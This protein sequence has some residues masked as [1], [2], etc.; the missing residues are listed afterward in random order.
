MSSITSTCILL[1]PV[2]GLAFAWKNARYVLGIP[3]AD[4]TQASTH[5]LST[6][7]DEKLVELVG[8]PTPYSDLEQT[9]PV[10]YR[11]V[12]QISN[13]IYSGSLAFLYRQYLYIATFTALFFFIVMFV[14]A[15]ASGWAVGLL[16]AFAYLVGS[17][18]SVISGYIGMRIATLA[19]GRTAI[20]SNRVD[21]AFSVAFRAGCV[22]GFALVSLGLLVLMLLLGCFRIY[23]YSV[24][25]ESATAMYKLYISLAGY[26]L[27]GSSV[28]LFSRVGGGIYT[29]AADVGADLVGKIEASIPEDD[30]R[31]P[32][33][34]ADQVGDNV[35]DIAGMGADLFGSFAE[36][37]CAAMV[38]AAEQLEDDDWSVLSFP[39]IMTSFGLLCSILTAV[40]AFTLPPEN[41]WTIEKTLKN[42]LVFSTLLNT[43]V[44][45]I[46]AAAFLPSTISLGSINATRWDVYACAIAGLWCGLIIGFVTEYYTSSSYAPVQEIAESCRTGAATNIIFGLS[47]GYKSVIAPVVVLC[48]SIYV[49]FSL[50]GS[51]G[52]A[53]AALGVLSNMATSLTIDAFGPIADNAGGVAEMAAL[54]SEVREITDALDSA[55]NTTAAVGKGFA[56]ASA[57]FVSLALFAAFISTIG[58]DSV[59]IL[60]PITFS[61]LL[62]GSMLPY[63][64]S[65][66]T[67]KAVG[68][69]AFT[70]VEEVRDQWKDGRVLSGEKDPDYNR[71]IQISTDASL[72]EMILP[73][74]LVMLNPLFVGYLL[75]PICQAGVLAGTLVSGVQ[76]AISSSNT[77]GAWDNAKKYIEAGQLSDCDGKGSAEHK[78]SV[79]G[80][81]VGDP[82]KDTSGPSLNI[83]IKLSA[84]IS[85]VFATSFPSPG[86]LISLL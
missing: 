4:K 25:D 71:C 1:G 61:G 26:G 30:P 48:I 20:R 72:R 19:N 82:L 66:M 81:T 68:R 42:Q 75:G 46:A 12:E 64:F 41:T 80:D 27:G 33:V 10:N 67:M 5:S 2:A 49:S 31:N 56:V 8:V 7:D 76:L 73:G 52:V 13:L 53:I 39:L 77:G 6:M 16:T 47:L 11:K 15:N 65:S 36:A 84:I 38:I 44:L 85:L 78:A 37:T 9:G 29:K 83:L 34:I 24:E 32:A 79:V 22:M 60:D 3:Y 58:L 59:N 54:P 63:W 51:F 23:W 35:G 70:M 57:A 21:T 69:A 45:A 74:L 28:A 86:W 55:G 50:V 18:T 40:I 17:G 43:F 62:Y 14:V